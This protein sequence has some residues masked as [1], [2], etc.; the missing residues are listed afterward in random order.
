MLRQ[1]RRIPRDSWLLVGIMLLTSC[2]LV[3]ARLSGFVEAKTLLF[4]IQP[5]SAIAIAIV[6]YFIAAGRGDRVRHKSEKALIVGSIVAIWFVLYF[7]SGLLV[8]YVHNTLVTDFRSIALNI[9]AFGVGAFA[10]EYTRYVTML[11]GGRRSVLLLGFI[12]AVVFSLQQMTLENISDVQTAS[13]GIKTLVANIIPAIV[14]SFLLTFLAVSSGLPAMLT[15]RLG[16]VAATI[17]PPII[18]K[19]D[20]YL[21]GVSSVLMAIAVY[22]AI[23]RNAQGRET[24][25]HHRSRKHPKRAYDIML[26]IVMAG[27]VSFT[28]GMFSYKP[29]VILSNSMK[30][31]FS[32]G[33]VVVVQKV[34]D[35]M[36]IQKGDIVQYK[37]S[38]HLIT[39]RVVEINLA[40]DGSGERR[41]T[42]KGDNSPSAD[43]IVVPKQ[44][45]GVIRAQ[46]PYIGYP[47]VWLNEI[48]R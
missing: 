32:R 6:A 42:T 15:Y 12:V 1:L 7:M 2:T 36:D 21:I 33:S 43:P 9:F 29:S 48:T 19:Y 37:A 30:P 35:T 5:L 40:D 28:T 45:V 31:V 17:L 13:D 8:T 10:I 47:T 4:T 44:I 16:V 14:S 24:T 46:V 34:G 38:D 39:H 27:L 23:D 20:W 41:F 22:I 25:R 26:L 3:Y 11:V 18:P